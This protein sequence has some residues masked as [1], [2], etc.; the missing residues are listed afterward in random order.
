MVYIVTVIMI[1]GICKNKHD[2]HK[3]GAIFDDSV[4]LDRILSYLIKFS[5]IRIT[6]YSENMMA[7]M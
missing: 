6:K 7:Q 4:T 1:H 3:G 5:V 2:L